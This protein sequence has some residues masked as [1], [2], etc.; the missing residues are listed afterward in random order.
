MT[1]YAPASDM[2]GTSTIINTSY[3]RGRGRPP[4]TQAERLRQKALRAELRAAKLKRETYVCPIL[5]ERQE[6]IQNMLVQGQRNKAVAKIVDMAWKVLFTQLASP[7]SKLAREAARDI[8]KFYGLFR[9]RKSTREMM[10]ALRQRNPNLPGPC[11]KTALDN[12]DQACAEINAST[13]QEDIKV[14]L[15]LRRALEEGK[16]AEPQ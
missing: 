13:T 14:P 10:A 1:D 16:D 4:M 3:K 2:E 6:A 7:S 8:L 15:A 9:A 5:N 12:L 11:K